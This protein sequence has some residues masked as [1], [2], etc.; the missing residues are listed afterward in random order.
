M[1]IDKVFLQCGLVCAIGTN[2]YDF[3]RNL[4]N[5]NEVF[6]VP[7]P[8]DGLKEMTS[9]TYR[10]DEVLMGFGVLVAEEVVV[11]FHSHS[12]TFCPI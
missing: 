5:E 10:I 9:S 6:K 4:M 3:I 11:D 12:H 7:E 1:D 8:I 2:R